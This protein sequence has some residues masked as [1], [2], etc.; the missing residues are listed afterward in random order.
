MDSPWPILRRLT[1]LGDKKAKKVLQQEIKKRLE[2]N[3]DPV[4]EY[5][6]DEEYCQFLD[7][8]QISSIA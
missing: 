3:Y 7:H 8:N 6:I 5:L 2:S 4:T 1:D